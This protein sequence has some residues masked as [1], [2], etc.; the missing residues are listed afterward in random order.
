M[1]TTINE[2]LELAGALVEGLDG[3]EVAQLIVCPPFPWLTPVA[4][5]LGNTSIEIGAQNCSTESKGAFT[6]EISAQMIVSAGCSAVIIGHS[7]RRSLYLEDNQTVAKKLR[8]AIDSGLTAIFCIGETLE[9]R[10]S[11]RLESVIAEQLSSVLSNCSNDDYQSIVIAYEPVW[12][13]GT[14]LTATP[15]QAQEVHKFIRTK[16]ASL[17]SADIANSVSILYGG[18]CNAANAKDIFAQADIDGGLI[19]GASLKAAD[20]LTIARSF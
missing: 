12:A 17:S 4:A 7:E 9:E 1:N 16:V 2:A 8:A 5:A 19:G 6:G 11:G 15:E 10:Q 3:S 13:I 14:G 20:F 18:S